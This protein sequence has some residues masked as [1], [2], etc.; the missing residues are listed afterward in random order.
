[1]R[2]A[3]MDRGAVERVMSRLRA[4][5]RDMVA[6][7]QAREVVSNLRDPPQPKPTSE[8]DQS[9]PKRT[10]APNPDEVQPGV[11]VVGKRSC[12]SLFNSCSCLQ[13]VAPDANTHDE[14]GKMW[15]TEMDQTLGCTG[16]VVRLN[17]DS[18]P[19]LVLVR[20]EQLDTSTVHEW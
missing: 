17:R 12:C 10:R 9:Q 6:L 4:D 20:V 14:C 8:E 16:V 13:M 5:T 19:P 11:R 18:L 2:R 1:M 7:L 3:R 15:L